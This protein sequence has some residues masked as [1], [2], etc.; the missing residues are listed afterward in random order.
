M[1]CFHN[2]FV[3]S[4]L[5]PIFKTDT[6]YDVKASN[7]LFKSVYDIDIDI[8]TQLACS[9]LQSII[10]IIINEFHRDASLKENFR[11]AVCH[12]LHYSVNLLLPVVCV[13]V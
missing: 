11:A 5:S 7:L 3:E 8:G 1:H 10:I 4:G 6:S 9:E 2:L 12:V 13:A